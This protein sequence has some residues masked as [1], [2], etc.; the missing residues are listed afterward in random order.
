LIG[1]V[2]QSDEF[3]CGSDIKRRHPSVVEPILNRIGWIEQFQFNVMIVGPTLE[4]RQHSQPATLNRIYVGKL[5][6]YDPRGPLR[7][8]GVTQTV[9][10]FTLNNAPFA[11]NNSDVT[12][13]LDMYVEHWLPPT[14]HELARMMPS[15][16]TLVF[17]QAANRKTGGKERIWAVI[18]KK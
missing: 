3:I 1:S 2:Q 8:D 14:R 5:D 11:L 15:M 17:V 10:S 7:E 18:K 16:E 9:S 12:D 4:V 13:Y 6:Y